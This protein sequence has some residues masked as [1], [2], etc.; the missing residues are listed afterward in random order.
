MRA[1][2]AVLLLA[3]GFP[4][5]AASRV[6]SLAPSLTEMMSELGA[7]DLLVGRLDAGELSPALAGIPSV[8]RYGQL[9]MERLLSLQP[10]LILLW[11]GSVGAAQRD[12]LRRLNLPTYVA[13]PSSLDQLADQIEA[14]ALVLDRPERGK[15]LA[16]MQAEINDNLRQIG[17]AHV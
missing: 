10:D 14:L 7:T 4:A 16:A 8:G 2:L 9:D 12:Q 15:A 11:P 17:R 6:V 13:E 1:W 3:F 5:M